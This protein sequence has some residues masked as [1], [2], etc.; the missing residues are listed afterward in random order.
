MLIQGIFLGISLSF[1][2]GPLLFAIL[3]AGIERGFRA[4]LAVAGGIWVS[5]V[6]YVL[7]VQ[8]GMEALT[9]L[10]ALPDFRSGPG[11]RAACC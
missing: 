8:Y 6:L 5:D 7:V 10:T 1:M 11:W 4:G 9:T 3:Q 2:V